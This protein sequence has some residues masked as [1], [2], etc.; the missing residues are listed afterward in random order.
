MELV[1]SI[2]QSVENCLEV[3]EN[4]AK[5]EG[6]NQALLDSLEAKTGDPPAEAKAP[7]SSPSFRELQN[8]FKRANELEAKG[9]ED[10]K[11]MQ[12][13]LD[14]CS[15]LERVVNK[16]VQAELK[17]TRVSAA[18]KKHR[19]N[20]GRKAKARAAPKAKQAP[21]SAGKAKAKAKARA[22]AAS[23]PGGRRNDETSK[24]LHSAS[25]LQT[26]Q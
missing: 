3:E 20:A 21:K 10:D 17:E 9:E 4:L 5:L 7:P 15:F 22:K 2:K 19:E 24:K 8:L 16:R 12:G 26:V 1:N 25:C 14:R 13:L 6:S 18:A 23:K 11:V